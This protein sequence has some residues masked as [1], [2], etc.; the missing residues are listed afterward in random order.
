MGHNFGGDRSVL[1]LGASSN[2]EGTNEPS[3][4]LE[5][6]DRRVFVMGE[7]ERKR[8]P[9]SCLGR[10]W[11][12]EGVAFGGPMDVS[13]GLSSRSAI[14]TMPVSAFDCNR[15]QLELDASSGADG[16]SEP[17]IC[18]GLEPEDRRVFVMDEGERKRGDGSCI[19]RVW[20][21][22]GGVTFG[23][24][25]EVSGRFS[26]RCVERSGGWGGTVVVEDVSTTIRDAFAEESST[27]MVEFSVVAVL[28]GYGFNG[29]RALLELGASSGAEG[30]S[31]PGA[32]FGLEPEDC[33]GFV[34]GEG[35]RKRGDGSCLGRLGEEE[36]G[37]AFGGPMEVSGGFSGR[38]GEGGG[39][40]G[41]TAVGEDDSST[42]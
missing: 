29:D 23:G 42:L 19:G 7:G 39:G 15:A 10:L 21:E 38:R 6:E 32:W 22:E 8:G 36:G 17:C 9:S 5:I 33:R 11:E 40:W 13:R 20:E 27:S 24:P 12:E 26:S 1:E 4:G 14:A 34:L 2:T 3:F 18:F 31:E 16:E 30:T 41:G 37:V 25:L 28:M 35:E